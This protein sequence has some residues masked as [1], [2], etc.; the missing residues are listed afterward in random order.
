MGDEITFFKEFSLRL[1]SNLLSMLHNLNLRSERKIGEN[2]QVVLIL[3]LVARIY[4][5][6][7]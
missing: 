7:K 4:F 2:S 3:H 1:S 6:M 5:V